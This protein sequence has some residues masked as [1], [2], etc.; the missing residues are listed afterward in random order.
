MINTSTAYKKAVKKNRI[1]E[2]FDELVFANGDRRTLCKNNFKSYS[3]NEATSESNRFSIGA[4]VIKKYSASLNNQDR[5]FDDCDFEGA[6]IAARVGLKLEDGSWEILDKGTYRIVSAKAGELTVEITAYDEMLYFDR[7]YKESTLEYPATIN[8]IIQNACRCCMVTYDAS[9]VEMGNFSI[10]ERPEEESVTFRDIISYCAQIMGCFAKINH[11]DT[12]CFQWYNFA[13]LSRKNI[14]GGVFDGKT[15]HETGDSLD[16]GSFM[17]YQG[18]AWADGGSYKELNSFHN[19]YV[20]GE[21][22]VQTEDIR[23]TGIKITV[24]DTKEE[25]LQGEEGYVIEIS[26]PLIQSDLPT[27]AA[28]IG[29]KVIGNLF[30]P[31]KIKCISDPCMEAG[32]AAYVA[33]RRKNVYQTVITNTTYTMGGYQAVECSAETKTVK[34]FTRFNASER[35]LSQA[36]SNTKKKLT[37]YDVAVQQMNQLAMNA[38]GFYQ[39]VEERADGSRIT[40]MH[41]K[42]LLEES[43]T[44]YKQGIDG[45]FLSQDGG[46]SYMAGFDGQ[47]NAV[48]NVLSV[49]GIVCD[50][51]RGGT[52]TLGGD[53]NVNGEVVVYDA[54]GN[55]IGRFNKDGLWASNGYFGGTIKSKN[56]EI[57]GGYI[58]IETDSETDDKLVLRHGSKFTSISPSGMNVSNSIYINL[59]GIS[60]YEGKT[61]VFIV[62]TT[63]LI[64]TTF[65]R[66]LNVE[67]GLSVSGELTVNGEISANGSMSITS[68]LEVNGGIK[69]PLSTIEAYKLYISGSFSDSIYTKGGIETEGKVNIKQGGAAVNGGA[70]V[71]AGLTVS[72]GDLKM[73]SPI[74]TFTSEGNAVLKKTLDVSGKATFSGGVEIGG[75]TKIGA[76]S[77][78]I[79]FFGSTGSGKKTVANITTPSSA[80][81]SDIAVKLNSLLT[82]L[83]SYGLIG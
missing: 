10:R 67:E 77:N 9:T 22:S 80:T 68:G 71:T 43:E 46:K 3:I 7:P 36:S 40:Y 61:R 66:N 29:E 17:D 41:D 33:D 12:L 74:A 83:R 79:G 78:S 26:N 21:M 48:L 24:E 8:Q 16:G 14:D 47:G 72:T 34:D 45:F 55:V 20:L 27:I 51:I 54:D 19:L 15:P 35:L 65:A 82:A 37:S 81:T 69:V 32:D 38:M 62:D 28:H 42:P 44:V 76:L 30:R 64:P 49:I 52:L 1:F 56:A 53:N 18:G 75:S 2:I 25:Y 59:G 11:L 5:E 70:T 73:S 57:T 58:N 23:I 39:T 50:W 13:A 31:L 60:V 63:T 6:T 4:A